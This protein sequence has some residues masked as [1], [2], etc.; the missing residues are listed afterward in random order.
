MGKA[1]KIRGAGTASRLSAEGHSRALDK[2]LSWS[3]SCYVS[4]CVSLFAS[5][6]SGN[7]R[8]HPHRRQS[9]RKVGVVGEIERVHCPTLIT[10][11][12]HHEPKKVTG[13]GGT[14]NPKWWPRI[15]WQ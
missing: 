11:R 7:T 9:S 4:F 13:E 3:V 10:I 8:R 14:M 1:K 12:S 15:N 5:W 2:Y 6:V